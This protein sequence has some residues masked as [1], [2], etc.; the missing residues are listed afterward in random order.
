L[1]VVRAVARA[2][3]LITTL[4]LAACASIDPNAATTVFIASL[5]ITGG[6]F[7]VPPGHSP[8]SILTGA[9]GPLYDCAVIVTTTIVAAQSGGTA[10]IAIAASYSDDGTTWN[11]GPHQQLTLSPLPYTVQWQFSHLAS[12][13]PNSWLAGSD[14]YNSSGGT[15]TFEY[16]IG[17]FTTQVEYI[18]R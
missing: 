7:T 4:G 15:L 12:N 2:G 9:A 3:A 16:G 14:I 10:N 13:A 17:T 6:S 8:V 1:G 18:K 11:Y 5:A